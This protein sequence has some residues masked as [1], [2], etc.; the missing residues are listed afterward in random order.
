MQLWSK[1]VIEEANLFNPAF[2]SVVLAKAAREFHKKAN[3]PLPFALA[4]LVLPIV[5]HQG[6]RAALPHSTITSL[7][8]WVQ[9][10]RHQLVEFSKRVSSLM[11]IT[12]EAILFGVSHQ[13]LALSSDGDLSLGPKYQA[14]T[15]KRTA[16]FTD[17]VRE[18]I[19]RAGFIGRW[20]AVGGTVATIY[21]AWGI[22]P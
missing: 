16:L 22:R 2:C 7:L 3:R 8:T 20:F 19:D 13:N 14:A 5:L 18:C 17:E 12:R 4:V 6:T 21:S 10:N 9:E 11:P 1:R 15:E